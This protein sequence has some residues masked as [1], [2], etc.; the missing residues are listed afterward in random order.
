MIERLSAVERDA[1]P[2][3]LPEWRWV[4]DRDALCRSLQ[5]ADFCD[6][7]G[8]MTKVALTAERMNHHP[9][10]FNIYNR[11]DITLSTHDC[12]GVSQ[13]DVSLAQA[14]DDYYSNRK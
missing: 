2:I 1:L 14:I 5:F 8:F 4:A 11:V 6:A 7:F 9:E 3:R 12:Q 10:W 13:K